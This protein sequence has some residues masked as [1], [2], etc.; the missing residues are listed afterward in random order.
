MYRALTV[1]LISALLVLGGCAT[2]KPPAPRI[3]YQGQ[4]LHFHED[5]SISQV[6]GGSS[7]FTIG[8]P[9]E[10]RILI[11]LYGSDGQLEFTLYEGEGGVMALS[12]AMK[13]DK[14]GYEL[15]KGQHK[16]VL[17]GKNGKAEFNITVQ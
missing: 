1:A 3:E 11:N 13:L 14:Y 8:S 12:L 16:M 15:K 5:Y 2:T 7:V 9:S 6:G 10:E 17:F 4:P